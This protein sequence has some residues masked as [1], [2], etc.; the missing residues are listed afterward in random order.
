MQKY[1][2]GLALVFLSHGIQSQSL[3][4]T[5]VLFIGNSLSYTNNLPQ[6]LTEVAYAHSIE[7]HTD[8]IA[9]AN[10]A[11][12]DHWEKGQIQIAIAQGNYDFVIIQQGPSSQNFGKGILIE[13]GGKIKALCDRY[14]S[15]LLYFMVWPALENASTFDAVINNHYEAARI[16]SAMICPVGERWQLAIKNNTSHGLYAPDGFH[17]S[18]KGSQFTAELLYDC[19]SL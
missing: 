17:P 5:R 19:M 3:N 14:G 2:L 9:E 12:M 4:N 10:Y 16:N 15:K 7:L 8:L 6:L 18:L 1:T 11:L 13:Y